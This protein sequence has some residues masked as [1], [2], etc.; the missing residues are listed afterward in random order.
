MAR[1]DVG[2]TSTFNNKHWDEMYKSGRFMDNN[3]QDYDVSVLKNNLKDTKM[4]IVVG[5][6]DAYIAPI[7]LAKTLTVLPTQNVQVFQP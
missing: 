7:D 5:T 3:N 6:N 4:A 2:G 1:N